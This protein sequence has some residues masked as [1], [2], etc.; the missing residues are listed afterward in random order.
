MPPADTRATDESKVFVHP[1]A[2]A[3]AAVARIAARLTAEFF[4]RT[5]VMIGDAA[6]GNLMSGLVLRAVVI[7][8]TSHFDNDPKRPPQ[9]AALDDRAP[10]EL[11]RPTSVAAVASS[12]GLPY[13]TARRHVNKL[14]KD[15]LCVRTKGGVVALGA[16]NEGPAFEQALR[17]NMANIRR[18]HAALKAA[19]VEFP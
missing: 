11:R 8:N 3:D 5:A 18:F 2:E 6:N 9:Y 14:V 12:L 10:D 13:E 16:V 4:F 17:A 7:G 15:G 1:V 19:G